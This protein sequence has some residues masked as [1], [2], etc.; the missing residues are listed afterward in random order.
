[1]PSQKKLFL[2]TDQGQIRVLKI[3]TED[4][5]MQ[6]EGSLKIDVKIN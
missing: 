1:M 6:I 3:D 2:A 4:S 5:N